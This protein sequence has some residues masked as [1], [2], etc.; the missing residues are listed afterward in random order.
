MDD[1]SFLGNSKVLDSIPDILSIHDTA[2]NILYYNKAGYD[3]LQKSQDEVV[4][5]KCFMLIGRNQECVDC[6][7]RECV[8][9]GIAVQTIRHFPDLKKWFDIRAY[10]IKQENNDVVLIIEHL[11]DITDQKVSEIR[12]HDSE[13]KQRR[14]IENIPGI[15]YR[16]KI[17][18]N[19]TML[20]MSQETQKITGYAPM[21]FLN[22]SKI[23]YADIIYPDDQELV[24]KT[25]EEGINYNK[26]FIIEYRIITKDNQIK[27]VWEKGK[28]VINSKNSYIDGVILD[29]TDRK[30]TEIELAISENKYR[31]LVEN[32]NEM[33]V[34]VDRHGRFT[35]VNDTYCKVFGKTEE[36]LLNRNFMP[37]VHEDD[38]ESTNLALSKL[39]SYPHK[40]Y[41]EQRALTSQGWRWLAWS[42]KAILNKKNEIVEIIAVGRDITE[43]KSLEFE[44]IKA[45]KL[46]E[47]SE[48]A[49]IDFVINAH[50][51]V[52]ESLT[53]LTD[54]ARAMTQ[55][56]EIN[57]ENKKCDKILLN[58]IVLEGL[59]D[60]FSDISLFE[61]NKVNFKPEKFDIKALFEE[62][63][64][65]IK[66]AYR[67]ENIDIILEKNPDCD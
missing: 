33:V 67:N 26:N 39:S 36:E 23:A 6:P 51:I 12:L 54:M 8:K 15:V 35:Y 46:A 56:V 58:A 22:N 25:I 32:Q 60:G 63:Y 65:L 28:A 17:D 42:D 14:L 10:P 52:K 53:P 5:K 61:Q 30:T 16:C 64:G 41:L 40:C 66:K 9:S 20:F 49:K 62:I 13:E 27:Y 47:F 4:G 31:L 57:H 3:F 1:L 43:Q 21:E 48:K 59:I 55:I 29:I 50:K 44:L 19:W 37:L 34:K 45:K 11:R 18:R 38:K 2:N 24:R 7:A